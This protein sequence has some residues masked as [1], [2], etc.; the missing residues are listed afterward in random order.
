MSEQPL[1]SSNSNRRKELQKFARYEFKYLLNQQLA[2]KMLFSL[3]QLK[4]LNEAIFY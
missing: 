1:V 2:R 3:L 4:S